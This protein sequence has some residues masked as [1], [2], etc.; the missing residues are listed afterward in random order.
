M[1]AVPHTAH[2][3]P[4]RILSSVVL[5]ISY[6]TPHTSHLTP[7]TSHIASLK[8]RR[9]PQRIRRMWSLE[10]L[11]PH[12][13]NLAMALFFAGRERFFEICK[14]LGLELLHVADCS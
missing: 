7:H 3:T 8:Q 2:R 6:L 1:G 4:H 10:N 12:T 11:S 9:T 5:C 14:G 13:K